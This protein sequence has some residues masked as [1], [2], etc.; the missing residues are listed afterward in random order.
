[1]RGKIVVVTGATGG[2]GKEIARGLAK[3]GATVILG[4]RNAE[5]GE[6]ARAELAKEGGDVSVMTLDVASQAS[7]RSFAQELRK[8]R[9][10]LDVLV[11]NAGAWF[12]DRRDSPDGVELTWA[13]N[14]L[15]PYLLAEELR[16]LLA[17]GKP[18]RIVNVVSAFASDY[19][20]KDVELKTRKYDGFK[21][22]GQSKQALRMVTWSQAKRFAELGITANAAAPGFV[23]TD[24]N[25]NAHGFMATMINISARLFGVTPAKG[26]E[27][28]IWVASAPELEKETAKFFDGM[29]E[30]ES[31][32]READALAELDAICAKMTSKISQAA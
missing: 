2:I 24:L 5:R 32:F 11:N 9:D 30:K 1:M 21:A 26:A 12:T 13:T 27:T 17:K 7:I 14:V 10:R 19:D 29:K 28:P 18:A 6:A 23:R 16:D 25:Q 3:K 15:G 8:K 31:K 20:A 4:A 22:Y